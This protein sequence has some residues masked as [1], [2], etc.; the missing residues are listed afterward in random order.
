MIA[1][2][3]LRRVDQK[4]PQIP[5]RETWNWQPDVADPGKLDDVLNAQDASYMTTRN[6]FD[7]QLDSGE[8]Y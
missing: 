1:L 2:E 5:S 3:N 8:A 7:R 4:S 6:T